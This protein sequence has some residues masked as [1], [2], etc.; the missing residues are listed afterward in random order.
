MFFA[1]LSDIHI[2]S[3]HDELFNIV[4]MSNHLF[5]CVEHINNLATKPDL[6]LVT[7]D[8]SNNGQIKQL[9]IAKQCLDKLKCPY[10]VIPGNHDNRADLSKIFNDNC[11]TNEQGLIHYVINEFAVTFIAIDS[12][13]TGLSG[14]EFTTD[15]NKWLENELNTYNDKPVVLFMHHPPVN[16]GIAET[17]ID[18]FKGKA[19]LAET[20][21]KHSNIKAILCGHIHLSAHTLW[22][23]TLIS[24]APSIG[25]RLVIDFSLE[26]ES[27]FIT[28]KPQYQLHHWT[29]EQ[30]LIT[31]DVKVSDTKA[32]HLF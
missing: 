10:Y 24:T 4:P 8:I 17:N 19:L 25:M 31:F 6:V 29:D 1:Q 9:E 11:Q 23:G 3:K 30:Q 18:G 32:G 28:E 26:Q 14:A 21:E 27:Q 5:E 2:T 15:S 20:I 16:M 22:H 12:C 7:G 13:K